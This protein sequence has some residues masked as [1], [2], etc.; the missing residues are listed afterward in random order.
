MSPRPH[1]A[2]RNGPDRL[3]RKIP[4]GRQLAPLFATTVRFMCLL[5]TNH[6]RQAGTGCRGLQE[7]ENA[8]LVIRIEK[9]HMVGQ[10][11]RVAHALMAAGP[12]PGFLL[13]RKAG[14]GDEI[15]QAGRPTGR[16]ADQVRRFVEK[17]IGKPEIGRIAPPFVDQPPNF[18]VGLPLQIPEMISVRRLR[19]VAAHAGGDRRI[20][21]RL[22]HGPQQHAGDRAVAGGA[23]RVGRLHGR[24]EGDI[25]WPSFTGCELRPMNRSCSARTVSSASNPDRTRSSPPAP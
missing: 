17:V 18:V 20:V 14:F 24:I 12:G 15:G 6:R 21:T 23:G 8:R 1:H 7:R 25:H 4:F 22:G 16:R 13:R 5:Y 9:E 3:Q 2:D 11:D 10:P 19:L